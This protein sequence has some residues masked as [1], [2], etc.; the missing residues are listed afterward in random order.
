MIW[1]MRV[2]GAHEGGYFLGQVRRV[3]SREWEAVT[4]KCNSPAIAYTRAQLAMVEDV[5]AARVL[6][7]HPAG[8]LAS[9][10]LAEKK[11]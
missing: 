1:L 9:R 3:R 10:V 2:F 11:R 5:A 8:C 7:V 6:F 4:G